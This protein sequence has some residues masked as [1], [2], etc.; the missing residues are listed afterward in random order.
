MSD[1]QFVL[2]Y[3]QQF[4]KVRNFRKYKTLANYMRLYYEYVLLYHKYRGTRMF[5]DSELRNPTEFCAHST[6]TFQAALKTQLITRQ[7]TNPQRF[8]GAGGFC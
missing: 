8:V 3:I 5:K 6:Q 4:M 2:R 1:E 7:P